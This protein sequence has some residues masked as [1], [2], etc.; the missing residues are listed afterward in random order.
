[1]TGT[2]SD[3]EIDHEIFSTTISYLPLIQ[4]GQL[5]I[6]GE[7]MCTNTVLDD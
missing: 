4:A 3:L 6:S 7:G 2:E 5:S 1:M